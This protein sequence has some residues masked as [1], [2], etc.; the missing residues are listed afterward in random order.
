MNGGIRA[1]ASSSVSNCGLGAVNGEGTQRYNYSAH[2]MEYCNGST[3]VSLNSKGQ[4]TAWVNF[5]GSGTIASS[6]NVSSITVNSIGDYTI[7]FT[8]AM[9]STAYVWSGSEGD[10]SYSSDNPIYE[11]TGSRTTSSFRIVLRNQPGT[12]L[13]RPYVGIVVFGP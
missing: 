12:L 7:N 1:G 5:N 4:A 8:N 11:L 9:S 13:G 2:A 10:T 3:W 6:Y